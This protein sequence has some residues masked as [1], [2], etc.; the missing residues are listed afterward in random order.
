MILV[1]QVLYALTALLIFIL[2]PGKLFLD[3]INKKKN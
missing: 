1:E 3:C 2:I